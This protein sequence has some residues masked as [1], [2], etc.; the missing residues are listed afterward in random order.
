LERAYDFRAYLPW[1]IAYVLPFKKRAYLLAIVLRR[2]CYPSS[3]A[4]V[5]A[6]VE[7]ISDGMKREN[8][9]RPAPI[10]NR[11]MIEEEEFV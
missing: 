11:N 8:I 9:R 7:W 2:S 5:A 4:V 10:A 3:P 1:L 6:T